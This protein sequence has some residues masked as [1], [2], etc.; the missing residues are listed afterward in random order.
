MDN[1]EIQK[2]GMTTE[3]ITEAFKTLKVK[4]QKNLVFIR[5]CQQYSD[6]CRLLSMLAKSSFEAGITL[7]E[8]ITY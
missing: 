4:V 2:Y 5:P 8:T 6:K 3:Q 7:E 1:P